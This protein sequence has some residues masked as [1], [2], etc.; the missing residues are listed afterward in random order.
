MSEFVQSVKV[1][2][3]ENVLSQE[4]ADRVRVL[5]RLSL[6]EMIDVLRMKIREWEQIDENDQHL[7]SL[8][9]RHAVDLLEGEKE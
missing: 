4:A 8:G 6:D 1:L 5:Y 9:L 7:Y 2:Q 3:S